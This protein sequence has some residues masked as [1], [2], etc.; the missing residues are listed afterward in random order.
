MTDT[1]VLGENL[2]KTATATGRRVPY[3][4]FTD[5]EYHAREQEKIFQGENWSFVALEAEIPEAGDFKS[6][7]IG[8]TPVI[9]TRAADGAVHVVVNRCAHRGAL[10]CRELRG[11][12]PKSRMCLSPMGL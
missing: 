4:V 10:V 11:N 2:S 7:F 1:A 9:V 3:R 6:T 5:P 8:E 12:R